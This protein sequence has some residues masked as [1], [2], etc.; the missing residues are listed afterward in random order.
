MVLGAHLASGHRPDA[1]VLWRPL[2]GGR[3]P[4]PPTCP[5]LQRTVATAGTRRRLATAHVLIINPNSSRRE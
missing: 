1:P 4:P 3:V 5:R 2:P